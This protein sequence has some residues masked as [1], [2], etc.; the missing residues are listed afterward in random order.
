MLESALVFDTGFGKLEDRPQQ[1]TRKLETIR[2]WGIQR[3]VF[4]PDLPGFRKSRDS[5]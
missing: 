3:L 4:N 1:M 2:E 5:A